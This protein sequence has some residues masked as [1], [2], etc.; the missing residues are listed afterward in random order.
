MEG[1][2]TYYTITNRVI[3]TLKLLDLDNFESEKKLISSIDLVGLMFSPDSKWIAFFDK[4]KIKKVF[5]RNR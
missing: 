3:H 5:N 2:V 1:I 4:E